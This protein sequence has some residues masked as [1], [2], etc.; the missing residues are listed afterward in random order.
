[1]STVAAKVWLEA[2]IDLHKKHMDG[3]EKPTMSSQKLMMT[4]MEKA[5]KEMGG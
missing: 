4:Y 3:S 1:M 2:A 5:M